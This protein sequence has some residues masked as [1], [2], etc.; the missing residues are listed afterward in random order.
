MKLPSIAEEG[1]YALEV[2]GDSMVPLYR[3]GDRVVVSPGETVRRG[4]RVVVRTRNGEVMIKV[5]ARETS[6]TIELHSV[7][8]AY[9]PRIVQRADVEWIARITWR[10]R[11]SFRR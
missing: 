10:R 1:V 11:S 9:A 8:P 4:D 5:L 7:N 2:S 3:E 6:K